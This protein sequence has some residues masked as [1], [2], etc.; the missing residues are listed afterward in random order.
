MTTTLLLFALAVI[1][2]ILL[3]IRIGKKRGYRSGYFSG[4]KDT[5]ECWRRDLPESAVRIVENKRHQ[6]L[7]KL[8]SMTDEEFQE[9]CESDTD[10]I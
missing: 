7:M 4:K 3:G 6:R 1:I 10:L 9:W 5:D 2:S 8:L